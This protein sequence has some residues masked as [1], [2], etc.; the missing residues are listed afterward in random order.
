MFGIF[1]ALLSTEWD[2]ADN[3]ESFFSNDYS[4]I[5]LESI[6]WFDNDG[7]CIVFPKLLFF[8]YIIVL[9]SDLFSWLWA[10]EF[11]LSFLCW[12]PPSFF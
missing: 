4:I 2:L 9:L 7:T 11:N 6:F 10:N 3:Y 5:I 8:F 1:N 12:E